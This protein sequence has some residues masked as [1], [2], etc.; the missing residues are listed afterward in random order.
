MASVKH[1]WIR[2][3]GEELGLKK[4]N[5]HKTKFGRTNEQLREQY[6]SEYVNALSKK[7]AT[8]S[9]KHY[10]KK[11]GEELGLKKWNDVLHKKLKTQKDN[12]KNKLWKNGRTLEEYQERYG[13]VIGYKKWTERNRVQSYKVSKQ[14]YIDEYGEE[15]GS[16]ICKSVKD[17][18][19]L[20]SFVDRYGEELGKIRYEE[21]CKRCAITLPK[22][23]ELYGETD[24][25]VRYKEWLQ[26]C[27]DHSHLEQGYSKSSQ[28]LFWDIYEKLSDSD[29]DKCNFAELN[30][31]SKF[32]QHL[33]DTIKLHRVDFKIGNKIIEFDSEYWHDIEQDKLRDD[34]LKSHNY[35]VLRVW[36][37]DWV[38]DKQQIIDKCLNFINETT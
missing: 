10:I 13:V 22:M 16:E 27:T 32:Y 6:G 4:W 30:E 33:S 35:T 21:N 12:F 19:S 15:L 24:G 18:S 3:Y 2:K 1:A 38:K 14:R 23:I 7:K 11:Y 29:K 9:K 37:K 20:K 34:F 26:K 31:E 28:S 36:Y 17:N 8:F 25:I 5:D